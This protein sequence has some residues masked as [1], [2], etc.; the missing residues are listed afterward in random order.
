M[1]TTVKAENFHPMKGHVAAGTHIVFC[2]GTIGKIK[3]TIK[4][5]QVVNPSPGIGNEEPVLIDS[6]ANAY[7]L[8]AEI[9]ELDAAK[10]DAAVSEIESQGITRSDAQAIFDHDMMTR[11]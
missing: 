6:P 7:F 8:T 1:H 11:G 3:A 2:D 9:L 4:G 10:Y 5:W